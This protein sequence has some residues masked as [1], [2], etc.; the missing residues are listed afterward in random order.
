MAETHIGVTG[1][2]HLFLFCV[3]IPIL[4]F[5]TSQK[6]KTAIFPPKRKFFVSVSSQ[7]IFFGA[8]SVWVAISEEVELLAGPQRLV[9]SVLIGAA[10][11]A[12]MIAFMYP[13]WRRAVEKRE[14]RLYFF[15]PRT[16]GEKALWCCVSLL[17]GVSEEI[18]YRG[19][20]FILLSRLTESLLAASLIGSA[21]F[22]LCHY[23]Q[24]WK[25]ILAIFA[26]ALIFQTMV[27]LTG[28][29]FVVMAVH[30]LY[31][32]TAGMMYSYF[33]DKLGYPVDAIAPVETLRGV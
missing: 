10:V 5:L 2:Y 30:F 18:T 26:F 6:L 14:R 22:A 7:Q 1:Y 8:F 4:A 25:S 29:L 17:A 3:L 32:V 33:G 12:A 20:L 28:S 15:M 23:V 19:V 31:D 21:I 11:L 16:P 27:Y 13:R 24:G 9:R